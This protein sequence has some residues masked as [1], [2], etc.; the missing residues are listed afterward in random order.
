M[1]DRKSFSRTFSGI[2]PRI[3]FTADFHELVRGDLRPGAQVLIRYDPRRI[4]TSVTPY[5]FGDLAHHFMA[6]VLDHVSGMS[7]TVPLISHAGLIE[8]P[9]YDDT[10]IGSMLLGRFTVPGDAGVVALWFSHWGPGGGEEIDSDYG[11]NF[12]FGFPSVQIQLTHAGLESSPQG[13]LFS[14][15]V[16]TAPDVRRVVV[17]YRIVGNPPSDPV[18][19][20]LKSG[21]AV[22]PHQRATWVIEPRFVPRDAVIRFKLYYW[23]AK[24][25]LKDDNAGDYYIVHR[26]AP[27]QVPPPPQALAE[28]AARW[29]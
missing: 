8:S 28:A 27:E 1:V 25:R 16:A 26:G 15:S 11:R 3:T 19:L 14:L 9:D 24:H 10:G 20:D 22:G 5:T 21:G 2:P 13:D 12:V 6:H 7:V 23:I 17:R 29:G 4:L 18:D